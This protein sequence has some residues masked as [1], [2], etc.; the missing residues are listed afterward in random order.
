MEGKETG[1]GSQCQGL[2]KKKAGW[3]KSLGKTGSTEKKFATPAITDL[4]Y[5]CRR[6]KSRAKKEVTFMAAKPIPDGYRTVTPYL[7]V[8]G[9]VDAIEFY[10]RAFGATARMCLVGPDGKVAHAEI[11][12][13]DSII[14]LAEE[15]EQ[16]RSPQSFGGSAVSIFLYVEDVD[17]WFRRATEAGAKTIRPVQD[18]FYGERLGMLQ[19]PFGHVWTI[20]T[21]KEDVSPEEI[22]QRAEAFVKQQGSK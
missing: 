20:S 19:D 1:K 9:A 10:K 3:L 13:G 14:M 16:F 7:V 17:T 12:I 4:P 6:N 5:G 22:S 15:T 18:Q 8:S 11:N 21:H 2:G